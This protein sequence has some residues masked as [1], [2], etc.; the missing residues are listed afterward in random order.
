MAQLTL[1][2]KSTI[3]KDPVFQDRLK[4]ALNVWSTYWS[5]YNADTIEKF[6]LAVQKRKRFSENVLDGGFVP[7]QPMA[8]FFL[9]GYNEVNPDL[10]NDQVLSDSQYSSKTF[11][12]FAGVEPGDE[13]EPI[14]W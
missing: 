3:A 2:Q 7:V 13:T 10:D 1:E 6:N 12:K 8:E 9:T 11:D 14:L 4:A 5:E